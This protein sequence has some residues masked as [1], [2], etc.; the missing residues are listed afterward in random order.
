V[1]YRCS[2]QITCRRLIQSSLDVSQPQLHSIDR[3]LPAL[4]LRRHRCVFPFFLLTRRLGNVPPRLHS[5][6][7]Q[8]NIGPNRSVVTHAGQGQ[9]GQDIKLFQAPRNISFM[10]HFWH[11]YF[12]LD[13]V[14]LAELSNNFWMKK[15]WHFRG[16]NIL[17][18]LLHIFRWS[19]LLTPGSTPMGQ[20]INPTQHSDRTTMI[21]LL[22]FLYFSFLVVWPLDAKSQLFHSAHQI[23]LVFTPASVL[24]HLSCGKTYAQRKTESD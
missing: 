6:A 18:P 14:K 8:S 1:P 9:S 17:W 7:D 5:N 12:I 23:C 3:T 10:F 24:F 13:G 4:V 16:Q 15:M 11:K 19:G 2:V 21:T 20:N 22:S